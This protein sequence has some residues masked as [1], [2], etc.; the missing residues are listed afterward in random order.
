LVQ[1]STPESTAVFIMQLD[2]K[3]L[4]LLK[5]AIKVK[6]YEYM[7]KEIFRNN[8]IPVP[9]GR[10][11]TSAEE[12]TDFAAQIGP[13]AIKSQVLSGGRGKAGGIKFASDPQ[14]ATEKARELLATEIKGL[15]VDVI[16]VEQK[17]TI[18]KELY[19]AITYDG[20]RRKWLGA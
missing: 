6:L 9:K 18:E 17:L 5:G 20:A 2:M 8:G 16:L 15:K 12:V 14:E 13:V 3:R 11:F 10:V 4:F 19:L 1:Q 7:A